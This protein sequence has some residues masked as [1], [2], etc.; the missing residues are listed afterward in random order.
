MNN[1][2]QLEAADVYNLMSLQT[3]IWTAT[4]SEGLFSF[5]L[6]RC[7]YEKLRQK[8]VKQ[9]QEM[10][11]VKFQH[12]FLDRSVENLHIAIS[13]AIKTEQPSALMIFDLE[14]VNNIEQVVK[15]TNQSREEFRNS[16]AFPILLWVTDEVLKKMFW[17]APDFMNWT[18][19]IEL[20]LSTDE[21]IS[22]LRH[23]ADKMFSQLLNVN[24]IKLHDEAIYLETGSRQELDASV[25]DLQNR[26]QVLEPEIK[27]SLEFLLARDDYVGNQI[28]DAISH[29]QQSLDFWQQSK[30]LERQGIVLFYMGLCYS[31]KAKLQRAESYRHLETAKNYCSQGIKA[32]EQTERQDLVAKFIG[33]LGEVLVLLKE[34]DDLQILAQKALP[35]HE[36]LGIPVYLAQDYGFLAEV[37]LSSSQWEIA[38]QLAQ[39]ALS[40][41]AQ[42]S[43]SEPQA[44]SLYLFLLARSQ[45]NLNQITESIANLEKA[46]IEIQKQYKPELDIDILKT[47]HSLYYFNRRNYL[48]AFRIKQEQQKIEQQYGFRAFIGANRLQP[49]PQDITHSSLAPEIIASGREQDVRDL[50]KRILGTKHRLTIIHGKSGV[51]KSSILTA[52]LV[53]ELKSL[54]N[55]GYRILPIIVQVYKDWVKELSNGITEAIKEINGISLPMSPTTVENL[56]VQLQKNAENNIITVII[57]DQFEEFLFGV[58]EPAKRKEFW[59][60]LHERL[61]INY[62]NIILSLREDCFGDLLEYT[63]LYNQEVITDD[64]VD[65]DIRYHLGNFSLENARSVIQSLTERS[66]FFLE[67]ELINTLVKDLAA[68][69]ESVRPIELQV[70][71]MQL[72]TEKIN[73]LDQYQKLGSHPKEE[74]VDRF[75]KEVIR[76]CGA[77]NENLAWSV[78]YLLTDENDT[79]PQKTEADLTSLL[80]IKDN[81]LNDLGW[82]LEIFVDSGLVF[83]FDRKPKLYQIVHDYLV[84]FIRKQ[85]RADFI[86]RQ[87]ETENRLKLAEEKNLKLL[88]C[89]LKDAKQQIRLWIAAGISMAFL[90]ILAGGFGLLAWKGKTEAELNVFSAKSDEMMNSSKVFDALIESLK[91]GRKLK[92]AIDVNNKTRVQVIAALQQAVYRVNES[93][94]LEGH[95]GVVTDVSYSPDSK[96]IVSASEDKTIKLWQ[97]NGTLINTFSASQNKILNVIFSPNGKVIASGGEDKTVRLWNLDGKELRALKGHSKKVTSIRFSPNGQMIASASEDN[98]VKLWNLDGKEIKT[99]KGHTNSVTSISFSPDGKTIATASKD[100][101]VKLWS[102]DGKLLKTINEFGVTSVSF[103]PNGQTIATGGLYTIKFWSLDGSPLRNIIILVGMVKNI[104]FSHDDKMLAVTFKNSDLFTILKTDGTWYQTFSGHSSAVTSLSFSLDDKKVV[105]ASEDKTVRLWNLDTNNLKTQDTYKDIINRVNFSP[106]N[107]L[108]ASVSSVISETVTLWNLHNR[109]QQATLKGYSTAI[110]FSPDSQI[111][112]S[113]SRNDVVKIW[114]ADGTLLKTLTG[115]NAWVTDI[116]F[117]PNGQMIASASNDNTVKIWHSDGKLLKTLKGHKDSIVNVTFS[118]DSKLVA[119]ASRDNTVKLWNS[120]GKLLKTLKGHSALVNRVRFSSDSKRFVSIGDDNVIKLWKSNG[121]PIGSLKGHEYQV[122]DVSFSPDNQIIASASNDKTVKLWNYDGKLL[123]TLEGHTDSVRTVRFSPDGKSIASASDDQMVK[124]WSRDG[125]LLQTLRGHQAAIISIRFSGDGKTIASL[126]YDNTVKLWRSRD[127]KLLKTIKGETNKDSDSIHRH[128]TSIEFSPNNQNIATINYNSSGKLWQLDGKQL[129]TLKGWNSKIAFSPDGKLFVSSGKEDNIK[130]WSSNGKLIANF[131]AHSDWISMVSFSPDGQVIASASED[132]TVKLWQ[133]DGKLLKTIKGH[134][135]NVTDVSFSPDG[136]IIASASWDKTVKLWKRD[137]TPITT[138]SGHRDKVNTVQFS[139]DG[140][141]IASASNDKTIKF[142]S[143]A[144]K[145]IRTLNGHTS[146]VTSIS[147]SRDGKMLASASTNEIILW[148]REDGTLLKTLYWFGRGDV[149]FSLDGK[150]I[151]APSNASNDGILVWSLDLDELLAQGCNRVRD[152]LKTNPNAKSDRHLCDG[153]GS[154]K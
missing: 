57:F 10:S 29:Y 81:D 13:T 17:L 91:A 18:S 59:G 14:L 1:L 151:A 56:L 115:H 104:V 34:W 140:K 24:N 146:S 86:A 109:K 72:Q 25:K 150:T 42:T 132:K 19:T 135:D 127:G 111:I 148:N 145:E 44:Q 22:S 61:E 26:E 38:R 32:F 97:N 60:F 8:M 20:V 68:E 122:L 99:L 50:I 131:P 64:L 33:Q 126:S 152:Y 31:R 130:I 83:I 11:S 70:V 82:F 144:G 74:L 90:T 21:L 53:P 105:S 113:A 71:G 47:L 4:A 5:I 58:K 2:Q 51:G 116:S 80:A 154:Q 16:F 85:E 136:Q 110:S 119:T 102:L 79:R 117:S 139:P 88:Q 12:L 41:L 35:L 100:N 23:N 114:R 66:Q 46:R 120:D 129:V 133:R 67:E 27:A 149:K 96:L 95:Q 36:T 3:L 48:K 6:L 128:I 76:D 103:S 73:T 9:V 137:G 52:G 101:T 37:A 75:L 45:Q 63:R 30:N 142:W 118:P 143:R 65:K 93:N 92:G 39:K 112:A 15:T 28:D 107:Q 77:E 55:K 94:R 138:I 124:I 87:K 123:Q 54:N 108:I 153:I 98:T 125:K 62:L 121:T 40:T 78:L 89:Q 141:T 134:N 49:K 84:P 7:N 69:M 43:Q 147:F 106:D